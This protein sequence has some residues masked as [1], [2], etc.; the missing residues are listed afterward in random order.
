MYNSRRPLATSGKPFFKAYLL[1]SP[2][3]KPRR[4]RNSHIVDGTAAAGFQ[5]ASLW[6]ATKLKGDAAIKALIDKGIENTSVTVVLIGEKTA[7]RKYVKYEIE[8]SIARGNGLL[9]IY[10]HNIKDINGK[11]SFIPGRV[12]DALRNAGAVVYNWDKD[13]FGLWVEDA[14]HRTL[15]KKSGWW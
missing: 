11:T 2:L 7:N 8:Q 4:G 6:E 13:R 12:P 1:A 15:R 9:G 5:D 3:M 14:Y 10:I